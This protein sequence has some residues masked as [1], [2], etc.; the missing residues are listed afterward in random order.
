MSILLH[1]YVGR[2]F[3][4]LLNKMFDDINNFFFSSN[5]TF[6]MMSGYDTSVAA[7]YLESTMVEAGLANPIIHSKYS[8]CHGRSTLPYKSNHALIFLQST[9]NELD[10]LI[11]DQAQSLY[12][13]IIILKST[14]NDIIIDNFNLTLKALY[15]TKYLAKLKHIDL[16]NVAYAPAVKKLYYFKGSM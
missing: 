3:K 14:Y 6:E 12:K 11:L 9:G 16:S 5:D 15:L 1:Y 13:E 2:R 10:K 7:K 4:T 8:F